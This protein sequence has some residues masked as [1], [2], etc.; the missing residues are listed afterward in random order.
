MLPKTTCKDITGKNKRTK[1]TEKE[2]LFQWTINSNQDL[3]EK[4]EEREKFET[5]VKT[6]FQEDLYYL[7]RLVPKK[8]KEGIAVQ[9]PTKEVVLPLK[10]DIIEIKSKIVFETGDKFFRYHAHGETLIRH[11]TYLQIDYNMLAN[12]ISEPNG[13]G[14]NLK[15]HTTRMDKNAWKDYMQ[16]HLSET[17]EI[18]TEIPD[19]NKDE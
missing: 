8:G 2:S 16:K 7:L 19:I 13:V 17:T 10:E 14:C 4:P 1:I 15:F 11:Y 6:I 18:T 9:L 5:R 12:L 3:R